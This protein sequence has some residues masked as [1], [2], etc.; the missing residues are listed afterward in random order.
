M[1]GGYAAAFVEEE[2]AFV[3]F[4]AFEE[5]TASVVPGCRFVDV[6]DGGDID[7]GGIVGICDGCVVK[8]RGFDDRCG[9]V[10]SGLQSLKPVALA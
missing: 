3:K 10:C 4:T 8:V 9:D 7:V 2:V 6:A 1:F 5:G